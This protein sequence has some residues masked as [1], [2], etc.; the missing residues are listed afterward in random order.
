VLELIP[1]PGLPSLFSYQNLGR[2][3]DKG[4]EIGIDAAANRYV[5]VFTNY[6]YQADPDVEGFDPRETNFPA[7]NRFNAGFNFSASRYLGNL[8]V[9]YS[10]EAYWQDVLDLRFAGATDAYTLVNAGFGVRWLGERVVTSLKV[11]NLLNEEVQ[12]HVFGDIL[13]RQVAGEVRFTF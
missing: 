5:N 8:A 13:R 3:K 9:N 6:S 2:V 11:T 1:A 12:Q 4:F 10:D 7:N